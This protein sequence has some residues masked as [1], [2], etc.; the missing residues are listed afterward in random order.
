[1]F[2]WFLATAILAV[3]YVF[4]DP[5]FDYR[6]LAVGSL[7]PLADGLTGGMSVLHSLPVSVAVL[8]VVMAVTAGRKPIRKVLLG[9]PI[10]MFLHLVFD[11]AWTTTEVFWWPISGGFGDHALPP[12]ERGWLSLLLEAVGVAGLW[13]IAK[14][15]RLADPARRAAVL[16]TG[17]LFAE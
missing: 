3:W 2:C 6:L 10:G 11:A 17:A 7:L 1:M 13:W 14:R 8:V 16:R 12:V 4:R 5:R 9:L 15:A